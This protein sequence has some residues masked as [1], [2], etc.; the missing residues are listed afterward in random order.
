MFS[1]Q[2]ASVDAKGRVSLPARM[3]DNFLVGSSIH[4]VAV[5][6]VEDK[7]AWLYTLKDWERVIEQLQSKP[8]RNPEFREFLRN[9]VGNAHPLEVDTSGRILLPQSLRE[10]AG[11]SKKVVFVGVMNK[12]EI[13]NETV[14]SESQ[15]LDISPYDFEEMEDVTL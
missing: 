3:R 15:Q 10:F 7:C 12:I 14:W 5:K 13:W 2:T 6:S 8:N 9:F 4:V 1:N 11:L